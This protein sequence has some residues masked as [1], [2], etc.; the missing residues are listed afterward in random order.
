MKAA[1][2]C[3]C[4]EGSIKWQ[5]GVRIVREFATSSITLC[6]EIK[7]S[8]MSKSE[9]EYN[10]YVEKLRESEYPMLKGMVTLEI[11]TYPL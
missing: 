9:V 8:K 1:Y 7:A 6:S 10:D 11:Q 5:Q 4:S 2:R 3:V